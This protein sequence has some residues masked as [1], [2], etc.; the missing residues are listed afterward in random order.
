MA[1]IPMGYPP[2]AIGSVRLGMRPIILGS[3]MY[4]TRRPLDYLDP[5]GF[6]DWEKSYPEPHGSDVYN[7]GVYRDVG[8]MEDVEAF[9]SDKGAIPG[10]RPWFAV[11]VAGQST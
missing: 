2:L 7:L 3:G 4:Q 8:F 6:S 10:G 5:W 9:L 11:G 1:W